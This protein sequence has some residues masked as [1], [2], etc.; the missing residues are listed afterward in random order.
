[1]V[2]THGLGKVIPRTGSE[3]MLRHVL[4]SG[5]PSNTEVGWILDGFWGSI[6]YIPANSNI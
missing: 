2:V 3:L 1:M 4:K 5:K 6:P